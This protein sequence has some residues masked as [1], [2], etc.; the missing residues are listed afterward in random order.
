LGVTISG[1]TMSDLNGNP[2]AVEILPQAPPERGD[3]HTEGDL[4]G[5]GHVTHEDKDRLKDLIK[6][7]SR[8]PTDDERMAGDLNGDGRLNEKDHMLHMRLL[9]GLPIENSP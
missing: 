9:N 4:D 3:T 1:A 7:K 5:D 6:P 2:L 8:P